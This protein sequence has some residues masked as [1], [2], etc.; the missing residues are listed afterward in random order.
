MGLGAIRAKS[1]PSDVAAQLGFVISLVSFGLSLHTWAYDAI[2]AHGCNY[3]PNS[4]V[5]ALLGEGISAF[6]LGL[7][8]L[9]LDLKGVGS[10]LAANKLLALGG[11][12]LDGTG[13]LTGAIGIQT[14]LACETTATG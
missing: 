14:D 4:I 1:S 7:G 3:Q 12:A 10:A 9:V 2:Q 6:I 13:L 11:L 5:D 8:G